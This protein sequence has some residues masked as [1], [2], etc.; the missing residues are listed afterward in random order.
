MKQAIDERSG[1]LLRALEV[2]DEAKIRWCLLHLH[3]GFPERLPSDVDVIVAPEDFER[4]PE[5]LMALP[6]VEIVQARR[7]GAASVTY[8]LATYEA[9]R[10]LF[11]QLDVS[12]DVR[13]GGSVLFR[14]E[15]FLAVRTRRGGRF[16]VPPPRLAFAFYLTKRISKGKRLGP[17]AID[18]ARGARLTDLFLEDQKVCEDWLAENLPEDGARLVAEAARRGC[19][20]PVRSRVSQLRR[21]LLGKA[22]RRAPVGVVRYLMGEL[23]K[24][25]TRALEPT[26]LALAF[27]GTDG[28]GKS[29]IMARVEKDLGPAFTRTARYRLRPGMPEGQGGD[30]PVTDPHALPAWGV[31]LSLSKL[32]LWMADY[33][34]GYAARVYPRL[35][36]STC[37]LFDRYYHDLLVDTARYRY[38][39]PPWLVRAASRLVLRPDLFVFLDAPPEV[40]QKRKQEISS[41]EIFRQRA[42]YLRLARGLPNAL[43]VDTSGPLEETVAEVERAILNHMADRVGR[44]LRRGGRKRR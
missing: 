39:V 11:L 25:T 44:R 10:L 23:A 6:D 21:A 9:G 12:R 17:D 20:E 31:T 22:G 4:V 5:V 14:A 32:G 19:W 40:L 41:A 33:T 26:G 43:T 34:L 37:V 3:D 38:G 24:A 18:Q 2:M 13:G 35:V 36:R 16:W 42:A 8:T 29:T 30:K 28:S 15:E 1:L 7:Y 27:L